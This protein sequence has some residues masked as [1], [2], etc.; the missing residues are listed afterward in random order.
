MT[1]RQHVS[2]DTPEMTK[3]VLPKVLQNYKLYLLA[4]E[5]KLNW[6]LLFF[7][8]TY[9]IGRDKTVPL[10]VFLEFCG[11]RDVENTEGPPFGFFGMVRLSKELFSIKGPPSIF[12]ICDRMDE[13]SESFLPG[14][15]IR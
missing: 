5:T 1:F 4:Q 3:K 11:R 13:K 12:L 7:R 8:V 9:I 15:P 2:F 10:P 6:F 14:A